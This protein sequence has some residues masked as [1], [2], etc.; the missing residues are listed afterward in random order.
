MAREIDR[1]E[2]ECLIVGGGWCESHS[3]YKGDWRNPKSFYSI[4][5]DETAQP[6]SVGDICDQST[7]S[8]QF[9]GSFL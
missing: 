6:D 2:G 1:F 4:D 5:K 9:N 3:R 8:S 7:L